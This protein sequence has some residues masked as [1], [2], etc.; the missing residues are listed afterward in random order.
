MM[1]AMGQ[2]MRTFREEQAVEILRNLYQRGRAFKGLGYLDGVS[3]SAVHSI[4]D[5]EQKHQLKYY[6]TTGRG[7]LRVR[8]WVAPAESAREE[9]DLR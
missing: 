9:E 7:A 1:V 2:D 4:L 6:R 8:P 5:G 3:R